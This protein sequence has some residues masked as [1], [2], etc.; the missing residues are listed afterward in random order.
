MWNEIFFSLFHGLSQPGLDIK[1]GR[2]MFLNFKIFLLFFWEFSIPG[3]VGIEFGTNFFL[4][5]SRP[6]SA[7]FG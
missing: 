5:L 7:R 4:S 2:M 3:R 6:I 1:N